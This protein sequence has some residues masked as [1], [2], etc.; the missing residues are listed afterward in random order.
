MTREIASDHACKYDL[1]HA[2]LVELIHYVQKFQP[3]PVL[4]PTH[5]APARLAALFADLLER[6][7]PLQSPQQRL[8]PRTATDYAGQLAVH[9]N[10]FNRVLKETTGRTTTALIGGRV[11]QEA[12]ILLKQTN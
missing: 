8:R 6:Q 4:A 12:K 2:C 1:Q 3:A 11:A 7:F 9:V 10:H 5:T